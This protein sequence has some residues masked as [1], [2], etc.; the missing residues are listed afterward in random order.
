MNHLD[1]LFKVRFDRYLKALG[2]QINLSI[3]NVDD[4]IVINI[5]L[6]MNLSE[7]FQLKHSQWLGLFLIWK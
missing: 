6:V 3:L 2:F 1:Q 4:S 7:L 5:H